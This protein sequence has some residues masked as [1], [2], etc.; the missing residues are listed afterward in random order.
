MK[1]EQILFDIA[2]EKK[3]EKYKQKLTQKERDNLRDK[4][5]IFRKNIFDERLNTHRL[6]WKLKDYYSFRV[7]YSDRLKFRI[8][9]DSVIMFYDI[10]GH[11]QV[12]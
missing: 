6:N 2:F 7:T 9:S 4:L 1:V 8:V 3:F 10:G 11:D 12:Y 5:M